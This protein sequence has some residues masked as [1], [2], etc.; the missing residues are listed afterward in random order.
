MLRSDGCIGYKVSGGAHGRH[1]DVPR[2][3]SELNVIRDLKLQT[4]RDPRSETAN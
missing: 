4:E 2:L 1:D 3:N